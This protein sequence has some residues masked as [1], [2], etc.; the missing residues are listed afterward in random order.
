MSH[1]EIAKRVGL[2]RRCDSHDL[3]IVSE[4]LQC[5]NCLALT[6][7]HGVTWEEPKRGK[8]DGREAED[9]M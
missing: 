3:F 9:G 7:D 5:G 1:S 6:R 8:G 4:G 2:S